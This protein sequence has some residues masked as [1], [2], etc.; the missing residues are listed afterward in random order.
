MISLVGVAGLAGAGKTTAVRYLADRSSG[1]IVYLGTAVIDEML[2]R[3][4]PDTRE[5]ERRVRTELR[6]ENGS[7]ALAMRYVDKVAETIGNGV[8]VFVDAIFTQAEFDLLTSCARAERAHLLAINAS[9]ELRCF[10][11][12]RRPDRPF[13]REELVARDQTELSE[14]GTGAVIASAEYAIDN[15]G[16]LDDFHRR[17]VEFLEACTV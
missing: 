12:A 9:F 1:E 3:G 6:Q 11:L 15:E 7:A 14:L 4:L 10:R 13:S 17:L 5:N 16:S 8:S 2:E